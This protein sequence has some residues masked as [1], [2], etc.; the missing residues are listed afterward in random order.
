ME[1]VAEILKDDLI[2]EVIIKSGY[3]VIKII[4][5]LFI[6][7]LGR[8]VVDKIVSTCEKTKY[9]N[10][11]DESVKSFF[12]SFISLCLKSI[13]MIFCLV[14]LGVRGSSLLAFLGTMGVGVGLALK[15]SVANL[16][17]GIIVLV[18]KNYR[19]GDYID[20]GGL[21]GEVRAINVLTTQIVTFDNK[22]ITV[23][24]GNIT[25]N[26]LTNYSTKKVRR[27][28][29]TVSVSYDDNLAHARKALMDMVEKTKGVISVPALRYLWGSLQIIR[30]I[31]L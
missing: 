13:L 9:Y 7:K 8:R 22:S 11:L 6:Y 15:D 16:A 4:S 29:I 5:V 24:N 21:S 19:V 20:V 10:D 12:N 2:A 31:Y 27:V 26:P 17:G 14:Q 18:F 1:K 28:D 23:P 3:A 25:A 30:L